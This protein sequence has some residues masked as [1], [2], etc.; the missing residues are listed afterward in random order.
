MSLKRIYELLLAGIVVVFHYQVCAQQSG[1]LEYIKEAK[2]STKKSRVKLI[3]DVTDLN[4]T[5]G[6]L[7]KGELEL[8][9]SGLP[10]TLQLN[11]EFI[12]NGYSVA[13]GDILTIHFKDGSRY[14]VI[15][16]DKKSGSGKI[17]FTLLRARDEQRIMDYDDKVFYEKLRDVDISSFR[18]NVDNSYRIIEVSLFKSDLIRKT[19]TCLI[20]GNLNP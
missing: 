13:S 18:L 3:F 8:S 9:D 7:I 20:D 6:K 1:C 11:F 19:I 14:E 16:S 4:A 15:Y 2:H 17:V 5:A 10:L 12:D